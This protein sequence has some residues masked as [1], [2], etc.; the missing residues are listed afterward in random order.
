MSGDVVTTTERL[1]AAA[2]PAPAFTHEEQVEAAD[3][4][5]IAVIMTVIMVIP[6]VLRFV[7]TQ[8]ADEHGV[9]FVL[10]LISAVAGAGTALLSTGTAVAMLH[11]TGQSVPAAR[12]RVRAAQRVVGTGLS[13][14]AVFFVTWWV[15]LA[16]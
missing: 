14:S 12:R 9:R 8:S 16:A 13:L 7:L 3:W 11:T 4:V 2:E 6:F 10:G 5:A 1:P 15:V